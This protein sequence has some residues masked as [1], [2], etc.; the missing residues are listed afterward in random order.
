M[1]DSVA[2]VRPRR[3]IV[4]VMDSVGIGELP[5]AAAYGDEGSN[6]LGNISAHVRLQL[7]TLSA[8]GLTRLVGL[9]DQPAPPVAPMAAYG[10]MREASPGKDSVT[11]HW[12]L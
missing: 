9:R 1:A 7:P 8:L 3:V 12:E 6:T 10:R 11:G 5:D 4:I 2:G